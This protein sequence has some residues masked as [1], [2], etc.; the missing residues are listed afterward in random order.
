MARA[1]QCTHTQHTHT[2]NVVAKGEIKNEEKKSTKLKIVKILIR[3][4]YDFIYYTSFPH[5]LN[6][7]LCFDF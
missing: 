3:Y 1:Q 7:I 4:L 5:L 2:P 6:L